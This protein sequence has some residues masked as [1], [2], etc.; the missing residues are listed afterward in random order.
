MGHRRGQHLQS[1]LYLISLC[2]E[3]VD[4]S[5]LNPQHWTEYGWPKG[6]CGIYWGEC[7]GEAQILYAFVT[8]EKT[9]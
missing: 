2:Q 9:P 8:R 1:V 6:P 4:V 5:T 3:L 7:A